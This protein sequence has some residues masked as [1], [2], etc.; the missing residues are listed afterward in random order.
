MKKYCIALAAVCCLLVAGCAK[1]RTCRCTA[2][3]DGEVTMIN[4]DRG[5]SC[6]NITRVGY[7]RQ[8]DGQL[9]RTLKE[10]TCADDTEE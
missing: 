8:V 1:D 6:R 9:V 2:T 10:V 4:A 5:L 7:E 3:A